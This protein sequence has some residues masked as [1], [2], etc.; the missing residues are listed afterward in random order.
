MVNSW[1]ASSVAASP[2]GEQGSWSVWGPPPQGRAGR[3]AAGMGTPVVPRPG[4][5]P[6]EPHRT[7]AL[8]S[9]PDQGLLAKTSKTIIHTEV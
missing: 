4:N 5:Q 8:I 3:A 1:P 2:W 6:S 7:S 9:C